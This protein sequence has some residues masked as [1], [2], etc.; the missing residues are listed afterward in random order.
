[1]TV[2]QVARKHDAV[3]RFGALSDGFRGLAQFAISLFIWGALPFTLIRILA[4][5]NRSQWL[6]LSLTSADVYAG[7]IFLIGTGIAGLTICVAWLLSRYD[8][9]RQH[10]E[11]EAGMGFMQW[12]GK[13]FLQSYSLSRSL[14]HHYGLE[15]F[16]ADLFD[17]EY[18]GPIDRGKD[19]ENSLEEPALTTA[20][21]GEPGKCVECDS[22]KRIGDYNSRERNPRI[23]LG[24]GV[25]DVGSGK[26]DVMDEDAPLVCG[27]RAATAL[28]PVFPAVRYQDR[29]FIDSTNVSSVPMPA[30]LSLLRRQ[31]VNEQSTVIHVYRV[32]PVPFSRPP[33][34]QAQQPQTFLNLIDTAFR[35]VKLR[36]YRDADLERRLTERY[37]QVIPAGTASVPYGQGGRK[38]YRMW[39]APIELDLPVGLNARIMFADRT[40][41]RAEILK[42]IAQGCRAALEVMIA[43]AVKEAP[44]DTQDSTTVPCA[45]AV[46][47]HL[48]Q[49]ID[50][51]VAGTFGCQPL[52]GSQAAI[53]RDASGGPD[54][55]PGLWEIC[56]HCKLGEESAAAGGCPPQQVLVR[57]EWD[58]TAT[59][60][61]HEFDEPEERDRT[62]RHFAA[63]PAQPPKPEIIQALGRYWPR[64]RRS[65]GAD[66]PPANRP[67]V[68]VL[69]SGGVFRGVF[70]VGV[71]NALSILGVKPD[72]VAGASVGS[73]T[74]GMAAQLLCVTAGEHERAEQ[75]ARLAA[76]YL[77]VDRVI[78]TDRFADF[79]RESTIRAAGTRF[80]LRQA[81]QLF[82]KYDQ[83][84][85]V[86]F[87]KGARQV[88]GGIERLFYINPYQLRQLV[89]AARHRRG[90]RASR[91]GR[92]LAQQWL[93][94]M[95][96]GEEVL[97]AEAL[98]Q[99]IEYFIPTVDHAEYLTRH[100]EDARTLH[101][102]FAPFLSKGVMLLATATNL[103]NG[104]LVALGDPFRGSE[105]PGRV[106]LAN[107][108]LASSAFPGVFRPRWAPEVFPDTHQ[109]DQFIDGGVMDN[110]PIDAV[111]NVLRNASSADPGEG[112]VVRRPT[113]DSGAPIPHLA[114]AASLEPELEA[115]TRSDALSALE[116]YWP[117]LR[118]RAK[119]L[120][121][122][123][124]LDNYRDAAF[125]ISRLHD[126]FQPWL[127]GVPQQ[128]AINLEIAALKPRWLCGTFAFHPMLG[129][130]RAKQAESIAH[131]CALTLLKFREYTKEEHTDAWLDAW[132][133]DRAELPVATTL[134]EAQAR[135]KT[136]KPKPKQ[137]VGD[138]WLREGKCPFSKLR[139]RSSIR[140]WSPAGSSRA[141]RSRRFPVST[142]AVKIRRPTRRINI[143]RAGGRGK[144]MPRLIAISFDDLD[145]AEESTKRRR[146]R[147]AVSA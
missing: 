76:V 97:G 20:P 80:S 50:D 75:L 59:S 35:A 2:A 131:G 78:L 92:R 57:Q 81:D 61:P 147:R 39:V 52:P 55:P 120:G 77:A 114:F 125:E 9:R 100:S 88:I 89:K 36:Q 32:S 10:I 95:N 62:D 85:L 91:L 68:S 49:C 16:L 118:T 17:R 4:L 3:T 129:Y 1:M 38:S 123:C 102:M 65:A 116:T 134:D 64:E 13:R 42:T 141:G 108:L 44:A 70:Q 84:W 113:S 83:P 34:R 69:F 5:D 135:W 60:W 19:W 87:D 54:T 104:Q 121:Y 124:K 105:E 130:R 103:T 30:L 142:G 140:R 27:L 71:V 56:Q 145:S 41:R 66:E 99:L 144:A 33:A 47:H 72:I 26:V 146:I 79:V 132:G 98:S 73:I 53:G 24:L 94:R 110:L 119:Q 82:R 14:L 18:Y 90:Q 101:G 48:T 51:D 111:L 46:R 136:R 58:N 96:A 109:I 139:S 6:E 115:I 37:S 22:A 63:A 93:D 21:P 67:L 122:N 45:R 127:N 29:L 11:G 15:K 7:S 40:Q 106:D 138:C 137:E 43:D 133:I 28:T 107:A 25:A 143:A 86:K 8:R 23:A 126:Q 12:Y 128:T 112:L 74:A 117:A 31:G